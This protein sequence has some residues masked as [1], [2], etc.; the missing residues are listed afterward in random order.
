MKSKVKIIFF[1]NLISHQ[2]KQLQNIEPEE[3]PFM[4]QG[5]F[6]HM[7]YKLII[8]WLNFDF[9]VL[10]S[11]DRTNGLFSIGEKAITI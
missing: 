8:F 1:K 3:T 9:L 7:A 2:M 5:R 6:I 4:K 11:G 10:A